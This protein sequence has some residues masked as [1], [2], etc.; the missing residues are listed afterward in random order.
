[1][2]PTARRG[3]ASLLWIGTYKLLQGI[4]LV[5]LA[6]GLLK[7]VNHDLEAT[8]SHWIRELHF[9]PGNRYITSLLHRAGLIDDR[10]LKRLSSL[11]FTYGAVFMVE[12]TGLLFK[13]RWAEYLTTIITFS[14]VPLEI[15]ELA[16]H[17]TALKVVILLV[18][19]AIG[20]YLIVMIR[21]KPA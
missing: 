19:I 7:A 2:S 1:M 11:T 21:R 8:M 3:E 16:K 20:I 6:T 10:T 4:M 12:G 13:Q 17:F 9:D 15:Y 18:N 5:V 14:L